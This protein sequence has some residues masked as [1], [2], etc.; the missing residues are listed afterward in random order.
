VI[1]A[2]GAVRA[3][4]A[5]PTLS[6][7][8]ARS[9][10]RACDGSALGAGFRAAM[11]ALVLAAASLASPG[12]PAAAQGLVLAGNDAARVRLPRAALVE[13]YSN[14]GYR[15]RVEGG[16]AVVE[17]SL[18]PLASRDPFALPAAASNDAIG[19]L[20]RSVAA[21]ST[22][23]YEAVSR[24]LAW[25]GRNIEYRLD[26][27]AAQDAAATLARRSGYCT[28][29][30]RLTVA[31]LAAVGIEAREVPG[32]VAAPGGGVPAG[33]HR[34]VEVRY[35][36]VGWV[37]SDPLV[38]HHYVPATYVRLASETLQPNGDLAPQLLARLDHRQPA[39][40]FVEAPAGVTVRRNV[41]RQR[42]ASLRI[43][44]GEGGGAG[45]AVLE[46]DGSRRERSLREG[47]GT[48]VGLEPGTYLLRVDVAGWPSMLKR[49]ILRDRVAASI[50]LPRPPEPPPAPANHLAARTVLETS[51]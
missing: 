17:V 46:G 23:R 8:R 4:A 38:T 33:F 24:L 30:A 2:A 42:A 48:F 22:S 47:T 13:P 21:G 11:S 45:L 3:S 27:S 19:A 34:W 44:V 20:A 6:S 12:T 40:L 36:D 25:V 51:K 32:F 31:L 7:A 35:E 9:A 49:V 39:D 14:S 5:A 10:R 1:A 50:H 41:A 28:G 16:E 26:R 15:L 29:V 18:A 43:T 37:F